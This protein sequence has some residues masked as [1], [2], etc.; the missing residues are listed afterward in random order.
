MMN[1]ILK[2]MVEIAG[3]LVLGGL[4]SDGVNKIVKVATEAVKNHKKK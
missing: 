3:G 1:V 4:A 2:H